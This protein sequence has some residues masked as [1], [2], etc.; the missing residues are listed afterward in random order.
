[1]S[2]LEA[3]LS[4]GPSAMRRR[5]AESVGAGLG[6]A[7]TALAALGAAH[8]GGH[9][10]WGV[11]VAALGAGALAVWTD[12]RSRTRTALLDEL[13]SAAHEVAEG[14]RLVPLDVDSSGPFGGIA[15][16]VNRLIVSMAEVAN[17]VLAVVARVSDL[18][19]RIGE[20]MADVSASA[21]AQEEAVEETASLLANINT[22]IRD[23]DDRVDRLSRSAE[24]S[25]SSILQMGSSVDEVARSAASL[26]E[27]V[28]V[29]T[30]AV[31]EMGASIR[32]VADGA[33]N[34]QRMAEET[35]SSTLEMDRTVQQVGEHVREAATLTDQ[36]S[37]GAERGSEAVAATIEDIEG[38]NARTRE[39]TQ[40]L[41]RLVER[42][43]EIG[44]TLSVIGEIND[45]TN[46]LSLNA[47]IIAAQAG[48]QGRAFLV[49]ANHVKTLAQRTASSTEEIERGIKAVQE[50]SQNAVDAMAAGTSAIAQ[51]VDRSRVAGESLE[52]IRHSAAEA[53]QRVSEI[54][55]AT[56]E[57][58]RNSN[59]VARAAQE[60][61][62]HVQQIT[63][64]IGEQSRASEQMLQSS[65]TA[66]E[67]CRH[68]HR[69]TEEQR[70]TGRYINDAINSI[71]EMIRGIQEST[72]RHSV[73]SGSVSEAVQRLLD[74]AQKSAR[75]I[76]EV[77]GMVDDLRSNAATIIDELSRFEDSVGSDDRR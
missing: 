50:E 72:A 48:E 7:I 43:A 12:A 39:A 45:E 11:G 53:A 29:S 67:M 25:A 57:Q 47:A 1:M 2:D 66:L 32:Q 59:L 15:T 16:H 76:P 3:P 37:R 69:S 36:V 49:V 56:E 18:P 73:A 4:S 40:V 60:T 68:V 17:R 55:R 75:Q 22:S 14:G 34:V 51:G 5:A 62:S 23:I 52:A 71:T 74:N 63:V 19:E 21:E 33:E 77:Q 42:I 64:A 35:A 54:A 58:T 6:A 41:Q 8:L 28:E 13:S 20:V 30:S 26:H 38:I 24:E 9:A 70:E 65:E 46:L 31:H 10:G 27:T 61:S 44:E